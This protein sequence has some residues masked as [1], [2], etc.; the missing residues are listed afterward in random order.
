[1]PDIIIGTTVR[2]IKSAKKS[3]FILS[4]FYSYILVAVIIFFQ[5]LLTASMNRKKGIHYC[6]YILIVKEDICI[7]E[8]SES[9]TFIIWTANI[10]SRGVF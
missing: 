4:V 7:E 1:M 10:F 3:P 8:H 2:P 9:Q 6:S 5:R